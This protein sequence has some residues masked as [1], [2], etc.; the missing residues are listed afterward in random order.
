MPD[1][2]L[3]RLVKSYMAT[4]QP[5]YTFG[6]QG[7]EPLLMGVDFY[8]K[9]TDL[10]QR[11]G[12]KGAVVSNGLQTNATLIDDEL[13]THLSNYHFLLGCSLDGP[14]EI[15]DRYRRTG[16][17]RPSHH[18]VIH[19]LR[20]LE[21][22][23]VAFNILVLVTQA[24]VGQAVEVYDYLVQSGYAF[25]QYIPCVEF[26]AEGNLLP[27]AITGAEWG[28]FLCALFDRWYA[29]DTRRVSIRHFDALLH[30]ILNHPQSICS[31]GR[32]CCQYF[33]VE[34]NGDIYPCDF[35]VESKLKIGN[36]M[37]MS[38]D[39]ALSS[40]QYKAFGAQ[41]SR[42]NRDCR[43]CDCLPLCSGDCLKYRLYGKGKADQIS[44][45]CT[46]WQQFI[47]HSRERLK[48]LAKTVSEK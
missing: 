12:Q 7:G 11:F 34:F 48:L 30:Q 9:V 26:D 1:E 28:D 33:L 18:R 16:A 25:H 31:L 39:A 40:P 41:K 19:G 46:G 47:R 2:V 14:P 23:G 22:H 5:V 10:Q 21:R 13:A 36:I 27:Y 44:W 17:R 32:N 42:W 15:H 20:T 3:K 4:S 38:W 45:L 37:K 29:H 43:A 24:N 35:F 8:K 6:W